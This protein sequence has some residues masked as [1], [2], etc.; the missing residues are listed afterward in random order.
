MI[1][2]YLKELSKKYNKGDAREESYY[3]TLETLLK[4]ILSNI[5]KRKLI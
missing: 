5:V 4:T 3:S 2:E 1:S